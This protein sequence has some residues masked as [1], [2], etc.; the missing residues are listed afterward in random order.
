MADNS[1]LFRP[2]AGIRQEEVSGESLAVG[3]NGL[4]EAKKITA[5]SRVTP[6]DSSAL[7]GV[8]GEMRRS[9]EVACRTPTECSPW[10]VCPYYA[11]RLYPH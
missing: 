1:V 9:L 11:C 5:R 10:G 4:G 3:S 6:G 8:R 7:E 2:G